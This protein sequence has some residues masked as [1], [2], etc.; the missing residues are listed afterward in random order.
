MSHRY[1]V[2]VGMQPGAIGSLIL[3]R[4]RVAERDWNKIW[5]EDV[6]FQPD[7]GGQSA[8]ASGVRKAQRNQARKYRAC[9]CGRD[10]VSHKDARIFLCMGCEGIVLYDFN[11][12]VE[13]MPGMPTA[14]QA[15]NHANE[16][17]GLLLGRWKSAVQM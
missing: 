4:Q 10:V 11:R 14:L 3:P 8:T 9:R 5:L 12:Q 2:W 17:N 6:V 1:N 13:N 16:G 15:W 7:T